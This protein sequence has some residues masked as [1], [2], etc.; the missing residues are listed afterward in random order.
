MC[1]Y[2]VKTT[3]L[4]LSL[5]LVDLTHR[6]YS[7]I[8][9]FILNLFI[10]IITLYLG[11]QTVKIHV[12]ERIF[13]WTKPRGDDRWQWQGAEIEDFIVQRKEYYKIENARDSEIPVLGYNVCENM[14]IKGRGL[15]CMAN[16][17]QPPN[18][19]PLNL[20]SPLRTYCELY[21]LWRFW[22]FIRWILSYFSAPGLEFNFLSLT[23]VWWIVEHWSSDLPPL[24]NANQHVQAVSKD[25]A[26]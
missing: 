24:P 25:H 16:D 8:D 26:E 15:S 20:N 18:P 5:F 11:M 1:P 19:H 23:Y 9:L 7:N 10:D 2:S 4:Q 14:Y 21:S 12:H 6:K 3:S 17:Y 22:D 13:I